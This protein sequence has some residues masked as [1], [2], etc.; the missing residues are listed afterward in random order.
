MSPQINKYVVEFFKQF[1]RKG[2]PNW[3]QSL[4]LFSKMVAP[5][6][7]I[8]FLLLFASIGEAGDYMTYKDATKPVEVRVKDLLSRMTL[9]EK[10]GQM[11]QI[12]RVV[13]T[14]DVLKNYYIGTFPSC[15]FYFFIDYFKASSKHCL[16]MDL[17]K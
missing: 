8:P 3:I 9:A 13:A 7:L 14:T 15:I 2:E 6:I 10:I 5:L 4:L 17:C 11:T 12:E 1:F 16:N